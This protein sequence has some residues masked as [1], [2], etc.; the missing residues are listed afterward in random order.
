MKLLLLLLQ[1]NSQYLW[2]AVF[3]RRSIWVLL[4]FIRKIDQKKRKIAQIYIWNPMTTR[5]IT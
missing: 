5:L 3:S 2:N 1:Q 4:E